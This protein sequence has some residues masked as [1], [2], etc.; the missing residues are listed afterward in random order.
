MPYLLQVAIRRCDAPVSKTY[1]EGR[2]LRR[3]RLCTR[4]LETTEVVRLF[5]QFLY[6]L[7]LLRHRTIEKL[8]ATHSETRKVEEI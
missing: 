1:P 6:M 7:H 5:L 4:G 3:H 2:A 8:E